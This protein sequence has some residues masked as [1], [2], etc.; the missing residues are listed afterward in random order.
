[1][2]TEYTIYNARLSFP[3]L[4]NPAGFDGRTDDF[5]AKLMLHPTDNADAVS[6]LQQWQSHLI[7]NDLKGA[8]LGDDKV[9]LK[10][11]EA[12]P[13][14]PEYAGYWIMSASSRKRI[15]VFDAVNGSMVPVSETDTRVYSGA[16]AH[17]KVRMWAQ[18]NQYGKRVNGNLLSVVLSDRQGEPLEGGTV[19]EEQAMSGFDNIPSQ[20]MSFL[21]QQ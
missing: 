9:C 3:A 1:M 4:F 6:A 20:D 17:V 21:G 14:R 18:D 10:P 12:M 7:A 19:T 2:T 5:G 13:N 16:F 8:T 15:H 11:G